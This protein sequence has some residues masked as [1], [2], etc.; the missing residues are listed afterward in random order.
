MSVESELIGKAKDRR[1]VFGVV[2]LGYVG[3]PLA[4]ELATAGYRVRLATALAMS[5]DKAS[6]RREVETSLR[7]E[8]ELSQQE[9]A[10]AR[11]VL[12]SL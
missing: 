10:D 3:L 2:G 8:N 4:V 5:G 9:S 6:A 7:S 1:A 12:A 11:K